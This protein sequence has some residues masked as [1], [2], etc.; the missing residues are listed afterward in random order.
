MDKALF[1]NFAINFTGLILPTFVSLVTVPAYIKLLGVERYGIVALVGVYITY[2]GVLDLGMGI[3]TENRVSRARQAHFGEA[4]ERTLWSACW[5]N[6]VTGVLGGVAIYAAARLYLPHTTAV[7]IAG[8]RELNAALPWLALGVPAANIAAVFS[9]AISGAQRFGLLNAIQTPGTFLEQLAP[10]AVAHLFG[11]TLPVVLATIVIVRIGTAIALGLATAK[12]LRIGTIRAPAWRTVR[13]LFGYGSWITLANT[14]T[15][16][17][18]TFDA[19]M[20]G[21]AMGARFVTY[22]TVPQNLVARL[23]LLPLSLT[24]TLFPRLVSCEHEHANTLAQQSMTFLTALFTPIAIVAMF[25]IGPFLDL[26]VGH[27]LS[28]I[29]SPVGRMLT[30]AVWLAGQSNVIRVLMQAHTHPGTVARLGLCELPFFA[31]A[32][33]LAIAHFGMTGASVAVVARGFIDYAILLHLSGIR[34][35][36]IAGD[37]LLHLAFLVV[38]LLLAGA[39]AALPLLAGAGVLLLAANAGTSLY[40]FPTLRD[41]GWALFV[42]FGVRKSA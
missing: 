4:I 28:A 2:F 11:P 15:T 8:H 32:L 5:T 37:M 29:S 10:L 13:D 1:R 38:S 33:W 27:G 14:V 20:V 9:A 35:R 22:Y 12:T 39:I 19:V 41:M 7:P 21:A 16:V 17:F 3:A 23:G 36:A 24:R 26:W 18:E 6:L 31:A 34:A 30:I 42:R 25:A 40:R